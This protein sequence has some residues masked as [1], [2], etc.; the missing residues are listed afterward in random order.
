M[1]PERTF[2]VSTAEEDSL[3][4]FARA[5]FASRDGKGFVKFNEILPPV[6]K[7]SHLC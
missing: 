4:Q 5:V 2:V 6:T 1:A 7:L 3:A